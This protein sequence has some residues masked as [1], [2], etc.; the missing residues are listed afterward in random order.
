MN[1]AK[2]IATVG[3]A[4]TLSASLQ[5]A[6]KAETNM[7]FI[8]DAS[9]SMWGQVD[10][11]AKIETAR[12]ALNNLLKDMPA[13]MNL[14]LMSYGLFSEDS[15]EDVH[16]VVDMAPS[17]HQKISSFISK[18]QPKGKT[19]IA[20]ALE[21]GGRQFETRKD[22]N[23][24]LV[25]ISDGIESCNGDPCAVAA[26]LSKKGINVKVHVVGFA[27]GDKDSKQLAC[28]S[29]N[30]GGKFFHAKNTQNFKDAVAEVKQLAEAKPKPE[31]KPK[32][33]FR[34]DFDGEGLSENWEILNPN[35]DNFIV[36]DSEMLMITQA[37]PV[38]LSSDKMEN[39]VRLTKPLPKGDWTATMK[40]KMGYLTGR[41]SAYLALYEDKGNYIG[42][43]AGS[44]SY[45]EHIRGANMYFFGLKLSKGKEKKFQ[46]PI[47]GGP[48]GVAFTADSPPNPYLLRLK[49]VGRSYIPAV[50][51]LGIKKKDGTESEWIEHEKFTVLRPKGNLAIGIYQ[52]QKVP[53][54]TTT[55]IDW[56]KIETLQAA[57]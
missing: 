26:Q 14:G 25:L 50:K 37:N 7:L 8:I 21:M 40:F 11:I 2:T 18:I 32:E 19:P 3:L 24:H 5:A 28:I 15:C 17:N 39:I 41:E 36:E 35:P 42:A 30:G 43:I 4:V 53:G 6:A 29:E 38:T 23:N 47:W 57:Q 49:K 13:D 22:A 45:Y 1:I 48:R 51:M 44:W 34:D 10:G 46:K 33:Y 9:N 27:V 20:K 56:I 55:N 31:P 12:G 16:Y 52:S 54:E